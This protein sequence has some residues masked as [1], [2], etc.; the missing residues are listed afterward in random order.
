MSKDFVVIYWD[1]SAVL[2]RLIRDQHTA[3][4]SKWSKRN[5][6]HLVSSL[7]CAEV[8]AV[9][10]RMHREKAITEN[11]LSE[12]LDNFDFG[13]WQKLNLQPEWD[14]MKDLAS[15]WSLR[16]VDLW[17]LACAATLRKEIPELTMLT[18][19]Q[20]LGTA[21]GGAKLLAV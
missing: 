13:P 12:I 9:L 16:G 11:V 21:A 5:G 15:R 1:A 18:F 8:F 14:E 3:K 7:A 20:R 4:A 2:S 17:H 19:D 6:L 10:C